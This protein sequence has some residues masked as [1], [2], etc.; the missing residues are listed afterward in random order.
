VKIEGTHL[1]HAE[2]SRVYKALVDPE[3][4]KR[5]IPGCETLD[6]KTDGAYSATLRAGVGSVKGTFKGTVRLEDVRSPSHYRIVVEAKG[7]PGFVKGSGDI[8]LEQVDAA[9]TRVSYQGEVQIGGTIA[10]VGQRLMQGAARMMATQFFT[11]IEAESVA[12]AGDEPPKHDFFRTAL[13]W[14]SGFL[15]RLLSP[16]M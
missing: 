9:T 8:D 4:L 5:C 6:Q 13:R 14:F 2:Q 16:R 7:Q 15:R 12:N 3:V 11:S 10:G 1:L